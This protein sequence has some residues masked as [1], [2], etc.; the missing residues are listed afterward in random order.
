MNNDKRTDY[1]HIALSDIWH[2][3]KRSKFK[4]LAIIFITGLL[5]GL[6]ALIQPTKY[7]ANGTFREKNPKSS[8]LNS[9]AMDIFISGNMGGSFDNE[10]VT[11]LKSK[12]IIL[13]LIQ[14]LDLQGSIIPANIR[15]NYKQ[16]LKDN[17]I[18]TNAYLSKKNY[19]VLPDLSCP[20]KVKAISYGQEMPLHFTV[21]CSNGS[22][23]YELQNSKK[24]TIGK[25]KFNTPF[26]HNDFQFTIACESPHL[27]NEKEYVLRISPL[28]LKILS[29]KNR[30]SIINDIKDK[31]L[32]KISYQ[33]RNRH[34]AKDVVNTLMETYQTYLYDEHKRQANL[35]LEYLKQK[36]EQSEK[37]LGELMMKHALALSE[38]LNTSGFADSAKEMEFLA[39]SQHE[40]KERLTSN[41][42]EIKRLQNIKTGK[43]VYYDQ[44]VR[45]NGDHNIINSVLEEIR[46]YNQQRDSL[47]LA[48]KKSQFHNSIH[49]EKTFFEQQKELEEIK[50]H[51]EE[52]NNMID[53]SL[54]GMTIQT[55][56]KIF[57]DPRYI[58]KIWHERITKTNPDQLQ[59]EY[60]QFLHYL[61]NL[62]RLLY[63][64]ETVI[65]ERL[66]HQQNPSLEFQGINLNTAQ[67]LYLDYSRKLNSLEAKK[68][69]NI[70]LINQ[71]QDADFE[72]TSLSTV[73]NDPVSNEMI[74][75][76]SRLVLDLKDQNN[77]SDKEQNQLK[78]E[79]H[80][81]RT[82]LLLHLKQTN[83]LLN[84]NQDLMEEKI[85]SLQNI[86]LELIHQQ[87][88]VLEKNL[89]DYIDTR[90]DNLKQ[91]RLLIEQH[92]QELHKEMSTLPQKW[93]SEKMIEQNLEINELIVQEIAK[94][95]ESK[96]IS[97]QLELIQSTPIDF[98]SKPIHPISP[99][100]A[101]FSFLGAFM[102]GLIC[103]SFIFKQA[104]SGNL[105]ASTSNLKLLNQQVIGKFSPHYLSLRNLE[106]NEQDLETLRRLK[107]YLDDILFQ[108]CQKWLLIQGKGPDYSNDLVNLLIINGKK[109][110]RIFLNFDQ[111]PDNQSGLLQFLEGKIAFPQIN[112]DKVGDY[113][114]TGGVSRFYNELLGTELFQNLLKKL[115]DEYDYILAISSA[116]PNSAIAEHLT[117]FFPKIAITI[118]KENLNQLDFYT[119]GLSNSNKKVGY[120]MTASDDIG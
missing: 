3:C 57:N 32:L 75:K 23:A 46:N 10:A 28:D 105:P 21:I 74:Q 52:I 17:L 91:E 66:I 87:I 24:E 39:K 104:L 53:A 15:D 69:E 36:Q 97:H 95:V 42:L 84:L 109:P 7:E 50:D 71:M 19:P 38:D 26:I 48:L 6:F 58:I 1:K 4:I 44:Y 16:R 29:I 93:M 61:Y 114:E 80:L 86:T 60:E 81:E 63:V 103:M 45:S 116:Y 111:S 65:K 64:H 96:N 117:T 33:H 41:E 40:F 13:P 89:Q 99:H 51:I 2:L 106:P 72:I 82:F 27:I 56:S 110:I 67:E 14:S 37:K 25:G 5:G 120:I 70:F 90:L 11:I 92:M 94:M 12:K 98:A 101:I 76:A 88:S 108:G 18:V 78:E 68:R 62:K 83:Q 107:S 8:H 55:S 20:L 59:D 113:I 22:D 102:G 34:L 100:F 9:S 77:R 119:D 43:C 49:A 115:A 35:Q 79:L 54:Q 47:G 118:H 30:L 85:Y 73:L 31:K 112:K